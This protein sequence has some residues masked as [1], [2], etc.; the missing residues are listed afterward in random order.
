MVL[1]HTGAQRPRTGLREGLILKTNTSG[2]EAWMTGGSLVDRSAL[3]DDPQH[4]INQPNWRTSQCSLGRI[5]QVDES[6]SVTWSGG[7]RVNASSRYGMPT[8]NRKMVRLV[9]VVCVVSWR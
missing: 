6:P 3:H 8:E 9:R 4:A 1:E 7:E 2:G 5:V